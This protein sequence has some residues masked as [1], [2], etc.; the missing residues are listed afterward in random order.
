MKDRLRD[1]PPAERQLRTLISSIPG[2]EH[3]DPKTLQVLKGAT[4]SLTLKQ[5][6]T[7]LDYRNTRPT[8]GHP[9]QLRGRGVGS[10]YK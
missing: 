9:F 6:V 7:V 3:L 10:N 2:A 5:V 4:A 1:I 8:N